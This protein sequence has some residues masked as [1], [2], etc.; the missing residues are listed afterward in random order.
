M[1]NDVRTNP[2]SPPLLDTLTALE[3]HSKLREQVGDEQIA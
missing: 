3:N 1:P 2:L